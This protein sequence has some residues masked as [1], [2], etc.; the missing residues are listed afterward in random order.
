MHNQLI[1]LRFKKPTAHVNYL[2]YSDQVSPCV[3]LKMETATKQENGHL[4]IEQ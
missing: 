3:F 4:D 1:K 2:I